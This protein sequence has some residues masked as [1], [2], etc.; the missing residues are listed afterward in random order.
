MLKKVK[1]GC[2]FRAS[3][4]VFLLIFCLLSVLIFKGVWF[5]GPW[6]KTKFLKKLKE[7][8]LKVKRPGKPKSVVYFQLIV[9]LHLKK[10]C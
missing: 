10:F 3:L 1:K 5:G 6:K 7:E 4:A 2:S 9:L 8:R